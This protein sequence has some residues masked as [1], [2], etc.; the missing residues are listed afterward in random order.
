VNPGWESVGFKVA[1]FD[2]IKQSL[3]APLTAR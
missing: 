3:L 2:D 1:L